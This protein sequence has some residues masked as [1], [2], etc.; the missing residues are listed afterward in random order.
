MVKVLPRQITARNRFEAKGYPRSGAAAIVGNLCRE[1][2]PSLPSAFRQNHLDHG[3]NGLPQWRLERLTSYE[4]YVRGLH[5]ELKTEAEFWPWYGRMD[6][7]LDFIMHELAVDYPALDAK[8]RKGGDP[9]ALAA[10]FC[11][12]YERPSKALSGIAERIDYAKA[13]AAPDV[14]KPSSTV[15]VVEHL[16]TVADSHRTQ[17]QGGIVLAGVSAVGA[18]TV[19]GSNFVQD[20]PTWEIVSLG[21]LVLVAVIGIIGYFA[22]AAKARKVEGAIPGVTPNAPPAAEVIHTPVPAPTVRVAAAPTASRPDPSQAEIDARVELEVQRRMLA[23]RKA[24]SDALVPQGLVG[25]VHPV[26]DLSIA[27]TNI[28]TGMSGT[29]LNPDGTPVVPSNVAQ[30]EA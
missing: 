30:K 27:G 4:N 9:A 24:T 11:W 5:P 20:L 18:A 29:I 19:A 28:H 14:G 17:A 3:S 7:Q 26:G 15:N 25:Q 23:L 8:L 12:Q 21:G 10:D 2:G 1:S 13:L 6:H 22:N 16:H